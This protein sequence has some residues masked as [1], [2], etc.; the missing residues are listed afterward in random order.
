MPRHYSPK[1]KADALVR[2][3]ENHGSIIMTAHQL[4]INERTLRTWRR[5][6]WLQEILPNPPHPPPA[7]WQP[8]EHPPFQDN[9]AAVNFLRQQILDELLTMAQQLH[10]DFTVATPYQRLILIPQLL[11]RLMKLDQHLKPY[12]QQEPIEYQLADSEGEEP[13]D[14]TDIKL[15]FVLRHGESAYEPFAPD[16]L[17]Y[18]LAANRHL[19]DDTT[20]QVRF[21]RRTDDDE[22]EIEWEGQLILST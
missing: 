17:K 1:E 8:A 4:G 3:A 11:D 21:S 9:M 14:T 7:G 12:Q 15:E 19:G 5:K 22:Y 20:I 10:L 13:D 6:A 16:D 2:L 18:I